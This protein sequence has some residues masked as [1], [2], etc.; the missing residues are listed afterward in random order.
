[1][2][3]CPTESI[4]SKSKL[5]EVDVTAAATRLTYVSRGRLIGVELTDALRSSLGEFQ[6]RWMK[7]LFHA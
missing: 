5:K 7:D 4:R 1:M 2:S 6:C 3:V